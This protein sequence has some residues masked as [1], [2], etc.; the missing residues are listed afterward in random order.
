[1]NDVIEHPIVFSTE[2]VAAARALVKTKHT[3]PLLTDTEK[4]I[5]V[6]DKLWVQE[7]HRPVLWHWE[8]GEVETEY[9]DGT[10]RWEHYLTQEEFDNNPNDDYL[11]EIVKELEGRNLPTSDNDGQTIYDFS[12]PE[13]LPNWRKAD[14]MPKFAS[15]LH[16]VVVDVQT[17]RVSDL[18]EHEKADKDTNAT[19]PDVQEALDPSALVS[20][21]EFTVEAKY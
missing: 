21:I 18:T 11:V 10:K 4:S 2:E 17:K 6:G 15:R 19:S 9:R 14:V 5:K 8:D 7:E 16:L 20:V 3:I 1:M 13:N 12:K